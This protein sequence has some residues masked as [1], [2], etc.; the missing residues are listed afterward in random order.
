[1]RRASRY[2]ILA[3]LLVFSGTCVQAQSV[4]G[5]EVTGTGGRHSITGRLI[6]PSGQRADTRL[7]VRLES[8][9]QGDSTVLSDS[10]GNF[11]FR[12]LKG[13][14]YT[15]VVDGGDYFETVRESVFIETTVTGPKMLGVIPVS[16]PYT[17]QIYLRPKVGAAQA[18]P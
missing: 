16:R 5:I 8:P 18:R 2:S 11:S 7:A 15:V 13:G 12:S 14:N 17:V 9:G 1:M 4:G 3:T 10:N 6:F